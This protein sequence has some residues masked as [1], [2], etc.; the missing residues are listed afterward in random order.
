MKSQRHKPITRL[1]LA[2]VFASVSGIAFAQDDPHHPA[3][4]NPGATEGLVVPPAETAGEQAAMSAPDLP[5]QP[6]VTCPASMPMM[7]MMMGPPAGDPTMA[8]PM[9][10]MQAMGSTQMMMAQMMQTTQMMQGTQIEMMRTMQ[11]LQTQML[12]MQMMLDS[13]MPDRETMP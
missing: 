10:M 5:A 2:V 9:M 11:M 3:E 7:G 1:F 6:T 8:M 13:G 4:P 12:T